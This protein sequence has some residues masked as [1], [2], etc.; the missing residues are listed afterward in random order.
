MK[1]ANLSFI[2]TAFQDI[3]SRLKYGDHVL[4]FEHE[5]NTLPN[6]VKTMMF[7]E[8]CH[9]EVTLSEDQM[10]LASGPYTEHTFMKLFCDLVK[11]FKSEIPDTCEEALR[12]LLVIEVME[13]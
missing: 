7:C 11:K 9:G 12:L 13:S 6:S 3:L 4:N 10:Y 1:M 2:S 5:V 8:K